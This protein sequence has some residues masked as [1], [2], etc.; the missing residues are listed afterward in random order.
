M[1]SRL[2]T[3][4]FSRT[5]GRLWDKGVPLDELVQRFTVG[6]D[7]ACD[8]QLV[9]WDCLG[10]A[11]HARTLARAG[12][13]HD[14]E[15]AAL[16]CGLAEIDGQQAAGAF[17]IPPALEDCHTAIEAALTARCGEVG[18]KIHAGRS[19]N[20]QVATALRLFMRHHT[21]AWI[22]GLSALIATTLERITI[23]GDVPMPGYTHMQPAMPSS[24]G[25]WLHAFAEAALEQMHAGRELLRRLD[26]CPLGTGAGYGVPLALDRRYTAASLGFA[27][28]Q[29][30]PIDVQNSR[31]RL[32][33]QF[34]RFAAD[35]AGVVEKLASDLLLFSTAE[36]G[37]FALPE[38]LT[39]G[40]SIMPQKRNPDVL[41][42]LRGRAARL[43]ARAVEI[44]LIA[45]KL[46]SG[47]HRDLQLTKEP[48]L[49]AALELSEVLAVATRVVAS[50]EIDRA[51]L[52]A[53]MRPE[54]YATHAA[55]ARAQAGTP[56]RQAYR[57][58]AD[59]LRG[60]RF[61][62]PELDRWRAEDGRLPK[63]ALAETHAEANA[64]T[65]EIA[66]VGTRISRAE[67]ALLP[68]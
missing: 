68:G 63:D 13:L 56:F 14:A 6:D 1:E 43:R 7:P 65:A 46:P 4:E 48:T 2:T 20:D 15:L 55:L 66:E 37:F 12:L 58:V 36:F 17:A 10:S 62:P 8:L 53:A 57:Q 29:R 40:S 45:G 11:A 26:A 42:L 23:D 41:E 22:D 32:E 54:L 60:G 33:V 39:T 35:A 44:E 9:H 49:R 50:F 30:N 24:V 64:M 34:V 59:E 27:R 18:A 67:A 16:L 47:Y 3:Q 21:L 52:T 5:P 61:A 25:L 19:R 28:V 31:G 38:A 51:R